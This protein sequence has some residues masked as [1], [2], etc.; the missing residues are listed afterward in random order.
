MSREERARGDMDGGLAAGFAAPCQSLI[1]PL[2]RTFRPAPD[3]I[4]PAHKDFLSR[5]C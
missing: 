5:V 3:A 2:A 1:A 4:G